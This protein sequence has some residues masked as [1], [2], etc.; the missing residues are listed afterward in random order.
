[1]FDKQNNI[2][3]YKNDLN[4]SKL[5]FNRNKFTEN[6]LVVAINYD[7]VPFIKIQRLLFHKILEN[8]SNLNYYPKNRSVLKKS[9]V[10]FTVH[11]LYTS[12]WS[13][14]LNEKITFPLFRAS[15]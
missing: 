9:A 12:K 7:C 1:M 3:Q 13:I 2:K 14:I 5:G 10:L 8:S 15:V 4:N 11:L 6:I